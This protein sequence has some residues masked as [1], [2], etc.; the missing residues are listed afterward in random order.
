[1]TRTGGILLILAAALLAP[2]CA[3]DTAPYVPRPQR[4]AQFWENY[5][6]RLGLV[7]TDYANPAEAKAGSVRYGYFLCGELAKGTDRDVLISQGSGRTYTREEMTVQVDTA[8]EFLCP[9]RG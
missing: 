6:R 4:E 3:A 1:M 7:G 8:V 2:A 9:E 5:E